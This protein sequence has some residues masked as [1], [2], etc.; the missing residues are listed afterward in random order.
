MSQHCGLTFIKINCHLLSGCIIPPQVGRRSVWWRSWWY[1]CLTSS[2]NYCIKALQFE[3]NSLTEL[4]SAWPLPNQ[5]KKAAKTAQGDVGE[6]VSQHLCCRG[7][8]A[9]RGATVLLPYPQGFA[10]AW[11]HHISHSK[12]RCLCQP[13]ADKN[14]HSLPFCHFPSVSMELPCQQDQVMTS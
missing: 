6:A 11:H 8:G 4:W 9:G 7:A 10:L 1:F 13:L 12:R 2:S 5:W 3:Y 14:P